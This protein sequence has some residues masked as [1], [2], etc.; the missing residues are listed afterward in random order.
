MPARRLV[1]ALTAVAALAAVVAVLLSAPDPARAA[2][3]DPA[4]GTDGQGGAREG[5][6]QVDG[7]G[8]ASG[9]PDVLRVTVGVET[10]GETVAEA[11]GSADDAARRVLDAVRAEDVP[12]RDVRTVNVSIWPAYDDQGR[13]ITG[14]TA[15]HDLQVTL[16]DIGT[17]GDAIGRLVEA[18]GDAARLEGIS[19]ALEDDAALQ[20][21]AREQAI[22]DA[23][24]KAEEYAGLTGRDLGEIVSVTEHVVPSG[25]IPYFAGDSAAGAAESVP[26]APGSTAVT[27]TAEVRWALR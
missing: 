5:T 12:E 4:P 19:Y 17:A 20:T 24:R 21:E 8:T 18:G 9:T 6:V 26:I 25:P 23:R 15:R 7:L 22:A 2:P 10:T 1:P 11:L 14:Y 3:A 13:R 16:R 27:V